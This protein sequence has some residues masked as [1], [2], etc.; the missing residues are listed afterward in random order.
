MTVVKHGE[1]CIALTLMRSSSWKY[2]RSKPTKRHTL[3]LINVSEDSWSMIRMDSTKKRRL[4]RKGWKVGGVDEFLGLTPDESA[5]IELKIALSRSVRTHRHRQ[6]LTQT[7]T[8]RL[9]NSSQSRVAK[10]ESGDPSVSVDLLVR[11]LIA[12]GATR[13]DVARAIASDR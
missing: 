1:L 4:Q 11:S 3:S 9:L 6:N 5:Y 2:F 7:Q 13:K 8:A 10:I 12:L